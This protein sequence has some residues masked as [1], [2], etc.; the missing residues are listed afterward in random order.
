ML[1]R[2]WSGESI[3]L[4]MG[5]V[6]V[7]WQGDANAVSLCALKIADSPPTLLN[8]AGAEILAIRDI[9]T[10]FATHFGKQVHFTGEEAQ[11]ALLNNAT[12]SHILFEPPTISPNQIVAW[13]AGW[14]ARG[15]ETLQK[16]THFEVRDGKF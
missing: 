12:K 10:Q 14:I 7:I 16:P 8:I 4:S 6:N 5:Y 15:G 13:I 1:F 2:S 11:D 3:D 9:A